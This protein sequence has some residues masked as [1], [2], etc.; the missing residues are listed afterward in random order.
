L[1]DAGAVSS[2]SSK[3]MLLSYSGEYRNYKAGRDQDIL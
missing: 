3:G 1:M 2:I